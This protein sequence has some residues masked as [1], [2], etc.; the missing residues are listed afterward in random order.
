M[1]SCCALDPTKVGLSPLKRSFL[2]TKEICDA[3]NW[4]FQKNDSSLR[5]FVGIILALGF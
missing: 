4:I 5:E 3:S 1:E 2:A